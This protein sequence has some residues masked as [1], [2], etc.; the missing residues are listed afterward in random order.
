MLDA[1][2]LS[3]TIQI[4]GSAARLNETAVAKGEIT[5][6]V[7]R[8]LP[9]TAT[10]SLQKH[11]TQNRLSL[12]TERVVFVASQLPRAIADSRNMVVMGTRPQRA[13][14]TSPQERVSTL[15]KVRDTTVDRPK[16]TKPAHR[17]TIFQVCFLAG[18][19]AVR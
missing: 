15:A 1:G 16:D 13:K 4:A 11:A 6:I 14:V 12:D 10:L 8:N 9:E 17:V 2:H 3:R 7:T 5:T 19:L 18:A